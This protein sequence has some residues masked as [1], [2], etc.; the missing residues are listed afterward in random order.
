MGCRRYG[1]S[2]IELARRR[3]MMGGSA[4]PYD[5]EVEWVEL[6]GKGLTMKQTPSQYN[7]WF[8]IM[9]IS[10][11]NSIKYPS[12][13]VGSGPW[14]GVKGKNRWLFGYDNDRDKNWYIESYYYNQI[15]NESTIINKI[16]EPPYALFVESKNATMIIGE[17]NCKMRF[18]ELQAYTLQGE[19]WLHLKMV[20][21][22]NEAFFYDD[23]SSTMYNI[24]C[25]YIIG[26]DKTA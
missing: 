14:T 9:V 8:K 15:Y 10:R 5:A 18:Y 16:Y 19:P 7:V 21:K 25:D 24:K 2:M 17:T 3:M 12:Y 6:N 13:L 23:M 26:P 1:G 20:R 4:K 11:D 22:G